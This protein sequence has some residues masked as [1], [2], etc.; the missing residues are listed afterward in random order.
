[1]PRAQKIAALPSCAELDRKLEQKVCMVSNDELKAGM[2]H[3]GHQVFL[4]KD[5]VD[6]KKGKGYLV[7]WKGYSAKERTWEVSDVD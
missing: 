3:K 6:C 5:I 2:R 4:P 7:H 1:M